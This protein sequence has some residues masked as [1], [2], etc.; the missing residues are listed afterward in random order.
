MGGLCQRDYK[1]RSRQIGNSLQPLPPVQLFQS[2]V[3]LVKSALDNFDKCSLAPIRLERHPNEEGYY[4]ECD[5]DA[6]VFPSAA[7]NVVPSTHLHSSKRMSPSLQGRLLLKAS[8]DKNRNPGA[9]LIPTAGKSESARWHKACANI[10]CAVR[11]KKCI[12][13]PGDP[14]GYQI[15]QCRDDCANNMCI[16]VRHLT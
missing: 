16:S 7:A 3:S 15:S 4:F 9:L 10:E 8:A 1:W 2:L 11:C 14:V 12:P 5:S 13:L 6:V